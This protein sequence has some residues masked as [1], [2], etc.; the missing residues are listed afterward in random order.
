VVPVK[1]EDYQTIRN[2]VVVLMVKEDSKVWKENFRKLKAY[3]QKYGSFNVPSEGKDKLLA[4]WLENIR[5]HPERLPAKSYNALM[6]LGFQFHAT[7][8]WNTMFSKLESF[9]RKHGH[10]YVSSNE[11]ALE[12][13]F[14]WITNQRLSKAVLT[15]AQ[16]QK[17]NSVQFD[18]ETRTHK[19]IQWSEM[20]RELLDFKKK[21][22]HVKV[23][24]GF[25]ENK[26]LGSWV[27]RQR[28]SKTRNI[29]SA[30]R[31]KLLNKVG[32]LWKEDILKLREDSWDIRYKQLVQYKKT[33]GH[34]DRIQVRKD[35]FQL[36]L[37]METQM[38]GQNRLS[39]Q[40]RKKLDAIGF[41]WDKEDFAEQRWEE[42]YT[43]LKTYKSKHGHCQVKQREDFKLA[44]WLQR[45]KRDKN[46]ISR[47][48]RKKLEQ[49]GVKWPHE[50]FHETWES[51]YHT[52]KSFKT[53]HKHLIVP[54]TEARLYEWIQ[55]QKRLKAE[56]RL[57]KIRDQKLTALGFIWKGEAAAEKL[58]TWDVMYT[59]F[60][61]FK[62]KHG[63]Q[64]HI[65]L[66]EHTELDE[67]VRLQLHSKGKLSSYKKEKLNAIHFLW[68][69][70][71]HYWS[72]RWERMFEALVVFKNKHGHCDVPQKYPANQSLASWVN[73]QRMKKLSA[74][75]K[76]K[77]TALGFSWKNEISEKR[78]KQ[79][80]EEY[81]E[82][83]KMKKPVPHHTPLYSWIYQQRKNFKKLPPERKATLLRVGLDKL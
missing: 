23:P 44:V 63:T 60:V 72:E 17:L 62:K 50:L 16:I 45:N 67:W 20:Y 10:T 56:N 49:L 41:A 80:I 66:K 30:D 34:I 4:R 15:P 14:D 1:V 69:R 40:R 81:L 76:K 39:S 13:L 79:R 19:D 43:R 11:P 32:F 21:H 71:G 75:K 48:K 82:Y 12:S 65:K 59:K 46:R 68:D 29:L 77:L 73:G 31:V 51:M 27:S 36:G 35:H 9:Y 2:I 55:T 28:S 7:S 33:N 24:Q 6:K 64:Y 26:A 58:K 54:R 57:N 83:K 22:G 61:A 37:W 8:D 52:L 38:K 3:H 74:D 47:E 53:E 5:K 18:W 78:W 25:E 42:M 70:S